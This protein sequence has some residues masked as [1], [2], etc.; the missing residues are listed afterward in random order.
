MSFYEL[1]EQ[2]IDRLRREGRMSYRALKRQ[3]DL[4]DQLLEDLKYEIIKVKQ[5]AVDQKGEILIWT[6]QADVPK[7]ERRQLT[8][9]FCDLVD[10]AALSSQ[11]D[12]E[13]LREV[14]RTYQAT[15]SA[16]VERF[17]GHIAQHLGDGL[18]IY[19]GYPRAHE[20]DA[21][22][23]VRAGLDVV[24]AIR[25]GNERL[26]HEKGV[27]LAVRVGIHTGL[28]VVGEI[29]EQ[30]QE[31]LALGETPNIA[32]RI[33]ALA[34]PDK[35]IISSATASLTRGFFECEDLGSYEL[36]GIKTPVSVC[37]VLS[38]TAARSRLEVAASI[39]SRL[40]PLTG[41]AQ[42]METLLKCWN[43]VLEGQGNVVLVEGEP[44]IGKSR[45]VHELGQ[46]VEE[47][48]SSRYDLYCS[49]HYRSSALRPVTEH[50]RKQYKG[51]IRPLY[52]ALA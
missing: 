26:G 9:M 21:Q 1:L 41:R 45:L 49:P 7:A 48:G 51:P 46:H 47:K 11:L 38:V 13:D 30:T 10:S 28:V 15:C 24:E 32:A 16:V 43:R 12:P 17:E 29:G 34:D 23:A 35:V 18:L 2:V 3:F 33:Q 4:D 22:R 36:K 40:T 14:I 50:L 31:R 25:T 37:E 42:G 5:L 52:K 8:V 44:G 39:G 27:R 6:G 19:F 20:D